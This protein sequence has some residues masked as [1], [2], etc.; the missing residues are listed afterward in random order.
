MIGEKL[1]PQCTLCLSS[2]VSLKKDFLNCHD[3]D[4]IFKDSKVHLSATQERQRYLLH[5]NNPDDIHYR[6]FL[7]RLLEPLLYQLTPGMTGLDFGCGPTTAMSILLKEVGIT[8]ASYDPYFFNETELLNRRYDFIIC[9]EVV[10][11]FYQPKKEFDLL[12][13][14][15]KPGGWL[16][17]MTQFA[18][19]PEDFVKWGYQRDPTHVSFYNLKTMN[20]LSRHYGYEMLSYPHGVTLLNARPYFS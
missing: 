17:V 10:E 13:S 5:E 6:N 9:S 3:C 19:K 14:L 8:C 15:L 11:H 4:L 20:W 2:H 18:P 16:A 12:N 7:N 1:T